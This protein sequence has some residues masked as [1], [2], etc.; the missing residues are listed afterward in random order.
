MFITRAP[1]S[2]I[3]TGLL[4]TAT[5]HLGQ[6]YPKRKRGSA[7]VQSPLPVPAPTLPETGAGAERK[8]TR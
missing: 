1:D 6:L 5:C 7:I 4:Q 3:R 2:S 8:P